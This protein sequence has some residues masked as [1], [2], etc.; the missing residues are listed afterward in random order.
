MHLPLKGTTT[1]GNG[2]ESNT[3]TTNNKSFPEYGIT[4]KLPQ[5]KAKKKKINFLY[6]E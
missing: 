3:K 2:D 6:N 4:I 1:H 5:H